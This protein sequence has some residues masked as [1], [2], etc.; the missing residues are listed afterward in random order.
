MN[1][2]KFPVQSLVSLSN[3]PTLSEVWVPRLTNIF[4]NDVLSTETPQLLDGLPA[5][6]KENLLDDP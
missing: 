3:T 2:K 6:D 4:C 1:W 5:D